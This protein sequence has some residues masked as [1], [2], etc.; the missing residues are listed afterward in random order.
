ME[1]VTTF[2]AKAIALPIDNIDT[3]QIIPARFLKATDKQG[4]GD[5]LFADWRFD[6]EG[7]P[8]PDFVL[9]RPEA[10]GA[11]VLITGHNF[12]CGSS[13]EHAPWALRGY[14]F[15]AVISTYFA[16]IF[17]NNALKNGLL[18]VTVDAETYQQLVSLCEEGMST[19]VTVDLT[20][21]T[22]LLNEGNRRVGFPI[23]PFAR[24]CLLNGI[25]QLGFLLQQ[26]ETI[27]AYE[28]RHPA[29]VQTI[30]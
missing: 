20:T 3:D 13:R 28:A 1:P 26:E 14:G 24:Y 15:K 6:A 18:P 30:A 25:D 22:L 11:E 8:R 9:N 12:G 27:A 5:A 19:T 2:T 4:M 29:L 23:E 10:A 16:D 7:K 21:Q 17:R